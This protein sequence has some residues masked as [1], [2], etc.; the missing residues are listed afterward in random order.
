MFTGSIKNVL[1]T[2][3]S[4]QVSLTINVNRPSSISYSKT[5]YSSHAPCSI[6]KSESFT[7][8]KMPYAD[9]IKTVKIEL[10]ADNVAKLNINGNLLLTAVD[11]YNNGTAVKT[12]NNPFK[13]NS[14]AILINVQNAPASG[15][16]AGALCGEASDWMTYNL[17]ITF[18]Y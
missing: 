1:I 11:S 7:I 5:F 12:V 9:L 2:L 15:S 3:V 17:K 16:S 14:N 10:Y 18:N 6:S 13:T 8:D 4:K